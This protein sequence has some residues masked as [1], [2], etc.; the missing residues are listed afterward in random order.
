MPLETVPSTYY[1]ISYDSGGAEQLE[2]GRQLS[3]EVAEEPV[4]DVVIFSHGWNGDL[5]AARG[6]Y[7]RWIDAML[8]CAGDREAVS[9]MVPGFRPLIVGLHWPSKAWGDEEVPGASFA[10]STAPTLKASRS[11]DELVDDY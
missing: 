5:P 3:D 7:E 10:V 4:T 2:Q 1:L 6:Q 8:G 11:I 9:T